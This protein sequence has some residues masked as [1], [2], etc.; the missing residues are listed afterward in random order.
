MADA[1]TTGELAEAISA[2]YGMA[3]ARYMRDASAARVLL[4]AHMAEATAR[5]ESPVDVWSTLFSAAIVALCDANDELAAE[6]HTSAQALMT[7]TAYD[8]AL[9]QVTP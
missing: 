9:A 5:G 1:R 2:V 7:A 6:R 4:K 3:T 8:H